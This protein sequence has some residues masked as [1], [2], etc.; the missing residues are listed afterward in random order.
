[1]IKISRA[2]I[3]AVATV[4]AAGAF[5]ACKT[6]EE[7]YRKAY[8]KAVAARD[9]GTDIDSTVYGQVRRQ[10][11]VRT[12]DT[13]SGPVELRRQDVAVTE[14]QDFGQDA[15]ARYGVVAAQFKQRFNAESMRQR[16]VAA[17]FNSALVVETAEPLYYVVVGSYPHIDQAIA[18]LETLRASTP[19]ALR[20]P[21]PFILDAFRKRR[22]I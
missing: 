20:E 5:I 11:D 16:M 4:V 15:L 21:C 18:T 9:E 1:M 3:L 22:K 2:I 13:P 14:G 7:N 8:E 19:V 12:V 10:A 6:T 17:G